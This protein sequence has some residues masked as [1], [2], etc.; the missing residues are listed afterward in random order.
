MPLCSLCVS[1][2]RHT[3]RLCHRLSQ[4]V[5]RIPDPPPP[6]MS[7][8]PPLPPCPPPPP[9]PPACRPLPPVLRTAATPPPFASPFTHILQAVVAHSCAVMPGAVGVSVAL[10]SAPREGSRACYR[11]EPSQ[12]QIL[13]RY[14]NK[15]NLY[16]IITRVSLFTRNKANHGS[17]SRH[18]EADRSN[19]WTHA[20]MYGCT[21]YRETMYASQQASQGHRSPSTQTPRLLG[22]R[23]ART[24][25]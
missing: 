3:T 7:S 23:K 15:P 14:R 4:M 12:A 16:S 20:R 18:A 11:A 13:V 9:Y 21:A 24:G 25:T 22:E 19:R 6:Y 10:P 17:M 2:H 8:H 5:N 1:S